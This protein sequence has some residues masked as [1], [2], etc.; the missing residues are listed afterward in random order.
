MIT[1]AFISQLRR[2]AGDIPVLH[3]DAIVGDGSSTRY[4][5]KF[6]PILESSLSLTV[7]N[8]AKTENS[9][10]TVD[11]DTGDI[12]LQSAV[13]A[14]GTIRVTYKEV[15][16]RDSE[17]L[18]FIKTGHRALGDQFFKMVN[19]DTTGVTLSRYVQKY[20]APSACI[21][22]LKVLES[23]NFTTSGNWRIINSNWRYDRRAN[24]LL[25]GSKPQRAN[26]VALTY[27]R[28]VTVPTATS[29]VLDIEDNWLEIVAEKAKEQYF[30]S[31][32]A[33]IAQMG[34]AATD[35]GFL[36]V[37]NLLGMAKNAADQF[38]IL[39]Q[40]N[41]PVMPGLEIPIHDPSLGPTP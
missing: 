25:L 24:Q 7:N 41:K 34:N 36:K 1:S 22:I 37:Q 27:Q 30:R 21:R 40:R 19:F 4:A 13:G 23:D 28:R 18:G 10:F 29:S 3:R 11:Y 8:V 26:Y 2:E 14:T 20:N 39:R 5:T 6:S 17:W 16:F 9:F 35:E 38:E 31:R 33:Q 32:A 12:S 15:H